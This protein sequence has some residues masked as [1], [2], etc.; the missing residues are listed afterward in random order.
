MNDNDSVLG[1]LDSLL[2]DV[3][4][5]AKV[6]A[7]PTSAATPP[8]AIFWWATATPVELATSLEYTATFVEWL[9]AV[10][11]IP[12]TLIPVCWT[13]HPDLVQE[14]WALAMSHRA[15]HEDQ[16]GMGPAQWAGYL[17]NTL[18]RLRDRDETNTCTPTH[19][20]PLADNHRDARRATYGS[21]IPT[22]SWPSATTKPEKENS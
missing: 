3:S 19:T 9:I 14:L 22:W 10:Y 1:E 4:D 5:L 17:D 6:P 16:Q 13:A 8:R 11:Q 7:P 15:A 2:P 12:R 18:R 20:P 21:P